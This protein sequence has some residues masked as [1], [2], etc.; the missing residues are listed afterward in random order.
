[1]NGTQLKYARERATAIYSKRRTAVNDKYKITPMTCG[2]RLQALENGR[3][4]INNRGRDDQNSHYWYQYV[5][6]SDMSQQDT[7][8]LDKELEE[9]RLGYQNLLDQLILGD[10]DEALEL[11]KAFEN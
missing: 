2:E 7:V 4:S 5:V 9:L 8:R 6:F 3:F 11:L 10:A 1:V